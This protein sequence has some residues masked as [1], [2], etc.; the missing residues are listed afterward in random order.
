MRRKHVFFTFPSKTIS[1][2]P[3]MRTYLSTEIA[4][5]CA[6]FYR[7]CQ[8]YCGNTHYRLYL[9]PKLRLLCSTG[10]PPST[11]STL[12]SRF[13]FVVQ[14]LAS[15]SKNDHSLFR[16]LKKRSYLY[17]RID[18]RRKVDLA[19]ATDPCS[20]VLLQREQARNPLRITFCSSAQNNKHMFWGQS[21][22]NVPHLTL[23]ER[24]ST[25]KGTRN[26]KNKWVSET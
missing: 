26:K 12:C 4:A 13:S 16:V 1:G 20:G 19:R 23:C 8:N 5:S 18:A 21:T 3:G 14:V 7:I 10:Q 15:T 25:T 24:D 6:F 17:L 11:A 2:H 9:S 22:T